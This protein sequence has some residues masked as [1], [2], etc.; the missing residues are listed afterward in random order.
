MLSTAV[1]RD[2][3]SKAYQRIQLVFLR[4]KYGH[5]SP[6]IANLTGYHQTKVKTIPS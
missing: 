2:R 6:A 3:R 1:K 5:P 4:A